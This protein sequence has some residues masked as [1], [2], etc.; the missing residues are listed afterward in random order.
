MPATEHT[1]RGNEKKEKQLPCRYPENFSFKEMIQTSQKLSNVPSTWTEI[2]NIVETASKLQRIRD[3]FG[4]PIKVNSGYR[5]SAV[6][7]AVGGAET[8]AHMKGLAADITATKKSDNY[9]LLT[10]INE[11][12]DDLKFD[13][14]IIYTKKTGPIQWIHIGWREENP[15]EMMIYESV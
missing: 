2:Y 15:R 5:T 4:Q 12:A 7:K 6:N 10:I 8:S 1:K 13:Q 11:L 3:A 9:R 14:V